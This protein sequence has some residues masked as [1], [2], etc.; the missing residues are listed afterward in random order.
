MAF[1]SD[2]V[3]TLNVLIYW[4]FLKY[5]PPRPCLDVVGII[6]IHMCWGGI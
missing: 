2:L 1:G 3:D 5:L 6:S 4:T